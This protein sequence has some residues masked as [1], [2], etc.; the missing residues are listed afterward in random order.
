MVH[1]SS[2]PGKIELHTVRDL[3]SLA[4]K[5]LRP[6]KIRCASDG[7]EGWLDA[8]VLMAHTLKKDR[9][10]IIAHSNDNLSPYLESCFLK[11]VSRREKR[12]PIA[13]IIGTK[14]FY[15]RS[16]LVNKHV[17]IPRPET[18]LLIDEL[19]KRLDSK[20]RFLL[21]DLGTGSGAIAITVAKEFP[22]SQII[23][24]D[25][26]SQAIAVA[27][28]NASR[29]RASKRIAF[30]R[31]DL[32]CPAVIK[33]VSTSKL[34]LI[35]AAN[36]PYLPDS[37]RK[38]LETDI[39]AFEPEQALFSGKDGLD[40]IRWLFHQINDELN[41]FPKL[42]LCEF[43]SPQSKTIQKLAKKIFPTLHRRTIKDLAGRE[44]L[45]EISN[46]NSERD[47]IAD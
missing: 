46:S 22:R 32:L 6:K 20:N 14:D 13:Y 23:A 28:K 29:C 45:L 43:D 8:E 37:D 2:M 5:R 25:I 11:L 24:S 7:D 30:I 35:I 3:L 10:W 40:A 9:S 4:A 17:L 16:F 12:E 39:V 19:K 36:L 38:K 44:R 26:S 33:A 34:P 1:F 41:A 42:L 47:G 21:W 27:K 18:E 31:G 15:G